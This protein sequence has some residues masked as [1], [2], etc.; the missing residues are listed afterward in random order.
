MTSDN[1]GYLRVTITGTWIRDLGRWSKVA[2]VK[3][4]T[5]L[6]S[7]G[8][9]PWGYHCWGTAGRPW[10]RLYRITPQTALLTHTHLFQLFKTGVSSWNNILLPTALLL[11]VSTSGRTVRSRDGDR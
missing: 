10:P 11:F 2:L 6:L 9:A 5:L 1:L 3:V 4:K 7:Q 8:P